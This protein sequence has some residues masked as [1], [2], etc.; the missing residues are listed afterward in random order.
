MRSKFFLAIGALALIAACGQV[1]AGNVGVKFNQYGGNRGV[2]HNTLEPGTYWMGMGETLYTYPTFTQTIS[3][4]P[5]TVAET[6]TATAIN[7]Q[8]SDNATVYGCIGMNYHANP[9]KIPQLFQRFRGGADNDARPLEYI[10]KTWLRQ[11]LANSLNSHAGSVSAYELNAHREQ[12]LTQVSDDVKHQAEAAGITVEQLSWL[13]PLHY[14]ENVQTAINQ[15]LQAVQE[16]Q[17]AIAQQQAAQAEAVVTVT[18]ANARATATRVE[19]EAISANP[20][21]VQLRAIEKWDGHL[22]TYTGG[23][24]MPFINA[25][26]QQH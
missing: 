14:P 11:Q 7:F 22:P 19:A 23:G 13:G 2:Q 21:I 24:P 18:N 12:I 16:S 20:A 10:A 4:C 8:S 5:E 25:T 9:E 17:R 26:A 1:P 15:T 3:Y 6:V